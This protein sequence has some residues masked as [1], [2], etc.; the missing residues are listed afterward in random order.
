MT[1]W[2]LKTKEIIRLIKKAHPEICI[3]V[4]GPHVTVFPELTLKEDENIDYAVYGE[5]EIT[6]SELLDSL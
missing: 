1:P 3:V 4:G 2:Y 6:F 5:G